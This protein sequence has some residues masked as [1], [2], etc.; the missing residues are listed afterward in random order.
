MAEPAG[1]PLA[2]NP[3]QVVATY[4]V[5][6]F[7]FSSVFWY[8]IAARPQ[9]AIDTGL[10]RYSGFLLMWCPAFAAIVT[11]LFFQK[12]L[13]GFGFKIGELR[14]W[15]L[16][17]AIPVAVGLVM[18]GSAWITGIAPFL[19]DKALALLALPAL[20]TILI[21][22]GFSIISATG[23]ELGWRGL[24]V[25]ELGRFTTFTQVALLSAFIWG[26]WHLP[27]MFAGGYHGTGALWYSVVT[28]FLSLFGGSTIFAWIRLRSGSIWP[29]ALLH[30]SWNYCIQTFYPSLT[31]TTEAGGAML[32]EFGWFCV[33]ISI[34]LGLLFW[35]LRYMLPNM[36]HPEGG[37]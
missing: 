37:L 28:F 29:A 5:L 36:P 32:G 9:A 25:P 15:L 27:V 19:P 34:L 30:G 22:L 7:A 21:A 26:C 20:E 18:F 10:L 33:I 24:L 16:A 2:T 6:V 3:K 11:R 12:N 31:A 35:H 23:E 4:L 1:A 14:W 17:F 13:D 8:L